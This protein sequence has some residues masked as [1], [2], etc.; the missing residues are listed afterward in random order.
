MYEEDVM[1]VNTKDLKRKDRLNRS[2][3]A[4]GK[5]HNLQDKLEKQYQDGFRGNSK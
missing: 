5:R 2:K 4:R 3:K 1:E